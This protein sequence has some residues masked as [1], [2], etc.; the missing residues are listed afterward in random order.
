[1]AE[2]LKNSFGE[3]VPVRLADMV[4]PVYPDFDRPAFL[5]DALA[6]YEDLELT[7]RARQVSD[8]LAAHLPADPATAV[9][10]V[11]DSLGDL[12]DAPEL[13][14]MESFIYMP[15]VFFVADHGVDCF[16]ESML[17]QYELT[18]RFTAE[19]SI[20]AF[21]ERYPDATL[22]RLREWTGDPSMHVRRLVSEGTRPRLPWAPRLRGFQEDPSSVLELL[23]ILRDDPEEYVRRSVANNLNDIA[24]DH[25]N[26]VVDT[27]AR[28][29]DDGSHNR[30]RLVRH[31]LRTLIKQADPGAL[32]V[33][34]YD[35]TSPATI[36]SITCEPASVQIGDKI[37]IEVS[38][39]NPSEE[40]AGVLADL[41]V[42]FVKANG[43]AAAKVFKGAE[44]TIA[45]RSNT[46]V[47]KT[48]SLAQHSTRKHYP[49]E[50]RIEVL[51]NGALHPGLTFDVIG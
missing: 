32:A 15:L 10:I 8:A 22:Q 4:E 35:S 27:A 30:R 37:R 18:Q 40:P 36:A 6:G 1:M 46:L 17:A 38:I 24:K 44:R 50:H 23:E 25:P 31:G 7:P 11:I 39:E 26:V 51:L 48:I 43:H 47:R 41:K 42:H 9:R 12:A 29:W 28:W 49:G 19:F 21:I 14:G 33:L 20:R 2:P 3:D 16:E 34:G 13:K 45:P 5:A